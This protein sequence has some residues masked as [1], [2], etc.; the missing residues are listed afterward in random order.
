MLTI[1]VIVF[2]ALFWELF[3]PTNDAVGDE[4]L[5]SVMTYNVGIERIPPERLVS[6]LRG[7]R[8]DVI[9]LQE[10]GA[11]QAIAVSEELSEQYP[12]QA[13]HGGGVDGIGLISRYPIVEEELHRRETYRLP[14]LQTRLMIGEHDVEVGVIVAH[15]PPPDF[16]RGMCRIDPVV[17]DEI[18][19]LAQLA[20]DSQPSIILG[21]FNMV[22]QN[23]NY[24]L[25]SRNG[26]IDSYREVGWGFGATW[27]SQALWPFPAVARVDYVW[28]SSQWRAVNARVE[29]N[30]GSDHL[31]VFVELVLL[32][33]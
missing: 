30:A 18:A 19:W 22:D 31:P 5:L 4:W 24:R 20:L 3:L 8:A 6:F 25:L 12:F 17:A 26:L 14:H 7:S 10:L 29:E 32:E 28:H 15:P 23:D 27:P 16:G 2:L 9:G 21:D 11:N 13:L 33:E 1:G